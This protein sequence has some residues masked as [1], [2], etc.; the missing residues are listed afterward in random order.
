MTN[1]VTIKDLYY[2]KLNLKSTFLMFLVVTHEMS[3]HVY[4]KNV[5]YIFYLKSFKSNC[6]IYNL[7]ISHEI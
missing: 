7:K 3:L 2:A 5:T 4:V 1:G 6:N